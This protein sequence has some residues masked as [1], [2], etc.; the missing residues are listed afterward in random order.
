MPVCKGIRFGSGVRTSEPP[1]LRCGELTRPGHPFC[2]SCGRHARRQV[3]LAQMLGPDWER[4]QHLL[5]ALTERADVPT[6]LTAESPPTGPADWLKYLDPRNVMS[7]D[8]AAGRPDAVTLRQAAIVEGAG[9]GSAGRGDAAPVR[10]DWDKPRKTPPVAPVKADGA[11]FGDAVRAAVA[12]V[13][14]SERTRV[15]PSAPSAP[16]EPIPSVPV[17]RRRRVRP[18]P[19]TVADS[20][21]RD[22]D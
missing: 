11:H 10:K 7:R 13:G 18:L 14:L 21:W 20:A 9:A 6:K 12:P 3:V 1:F 8:V 15:A 16:I 17:M 2:K 4:R 5:L 22:E 19:G